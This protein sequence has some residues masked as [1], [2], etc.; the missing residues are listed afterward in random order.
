MAAAAKT[1]SAQ[2]GRGRQSVKVSPKRQAPA[3]LAPALSGAQRSALFM[4]SLPEDVAAD[5]FRFMESE[6][7]RRIMAS[8]RTLSNVSTESIQ[9]V[10]ED[11]SFFV[12]NEPVLLEGG[13]DYLRGALHRA[14]GEEKAQALLG[15]LPEPEPVRPVTLGNVDPKTLSNVLEAEHPQTIALLLANMEPRQAA[16][17]L[18]CMSEG[19]Q[20]EVM[21]RVAR[22]ERVSPEVIKD[23][24]ASIVAELQ[25]LG[26]SEQREVKGAE[27]AAAL[28]NNMD[29]QIGVDLLTRLEELDE[30][31]AGQIRQ[32]MFTF[33][34][35]TGVDERGMQ[36]IL[37]EIS[38]DALLLALKTASPD[39]KDKFFRNMSSRAADMMRDDLAAMGPARLSDVEIAQKEIAQIALR[40]Q[41]E[42]T[43]VIAGAGE[44]VV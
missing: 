4:L 5:V 24:E 43:I 22:L 33:E 36:A 28:I 6:E 35:L 26:S 42:G 17:V 9:K 37:K 13:A 16:T 31:L 30:R 14:V 44:D 41:E 18:A 10:F 15:E 2:K 23:I 19:V 12:D 39:L 21:G 1:S 25:T 20:Q 34:D 8:M 32:S 11:F 38:S 29:R 3:P 27:Q 40:L 7:I